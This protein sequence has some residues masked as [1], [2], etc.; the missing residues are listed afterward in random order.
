MTNQ[1]IF[2]KAVE[3]AKQNEYICPFSYNKECDIV[4]ED[5]FSFEIFKNDRFER[6]HVFEVI[7]HHAFARAFW[8]RDIEIVYGL[9]MS[10]WIRHLILMVQEENSIKYLEKFL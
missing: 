2:L 7:F 10:S 5:D 4:W 9:P 6:H 8:G 1:E 3:K